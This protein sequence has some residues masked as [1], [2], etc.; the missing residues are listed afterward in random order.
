MQRPRDKN[1]EEIRHRGGKGAHRI[2]KKDT[3]W[4]RKKSRE[5]IKQWQKE[6][7]AADRD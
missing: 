2:K 5:E 6:Q 1:I 3:K 4:I 7:P